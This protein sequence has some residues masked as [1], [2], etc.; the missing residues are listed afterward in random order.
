MLNALPID[1]KGNLPIA[2]NPDYAC[3]CIL[4]F[5]EKPVV[6]SNRSLQTKATYF[7]PIH[8][9][10][11]K[12]V[13]KYS[14][15]SFQLPLRDFGKCFNLGCHSEVMPY[16][17]YTHQHV[18]MGACC[19]QDALDILKGEDKQQLLDNIEEWGCVLGK[20]QDNQMCDLMKDS[21][22]YCKRGCK[23][24][25]DGYEVF[26]GWMLEHTGLDVNDVI[27]VQSMVSTFMLKNMDAMIMCIKSL[28]V[29]QQFISRC[30]VGGRVMTNSTEQYHVKGEVADFDASLYHYAVY[31]MDECLEN[32]PKVLNEKSY[33]FLKKSRWIFH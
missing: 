29:L 10:R 23:V 14:Y 31:Y 17:V 2:H 8:K 22:I 24:L 13:V 25:M 30:V 18:D 32:K 5:N 15:Q 1:R 27:A 3:K 9:T 33:E 6:K 7:N 4:F 21:G 20:G 28:G 12:I 11:I 26:R 19:V 16:G